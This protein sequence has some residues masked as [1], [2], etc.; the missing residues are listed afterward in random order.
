MYYLWYNAILHTCRA[1]RRE[2]VGSMTCDM[3]MSNIVQDD[4]EDEL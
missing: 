3:L 2:Y 4:G 1:W